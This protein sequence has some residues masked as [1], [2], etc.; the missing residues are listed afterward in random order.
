MGGTGED[1]CLILSDLVLTLLLARQLEP[2]NSADQK[3]ALSN[4]FATFSALRCV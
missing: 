3:S 2:A 1:K 4:F